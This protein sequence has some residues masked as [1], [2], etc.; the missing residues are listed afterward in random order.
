[1]PRPTPS[2][3]RGFTLIE[4]LVVIA[5]IA[6][7]AAILFPVFAQAREKARQTTCLSNLKQ[8]G[9]GMLM[10]AGDYDET[11]SWSTSNMSP[12]RS[13]YQNIE[14]YIKS[15]VDRNAN[16]SYKVTTFWSCPSFANKN[17]PR[18]PGDPDPPAW[19]VAAD[20]ARSYGANG[21][22]MP[23]WANATDGWFPGKRPATLASIDKPAQVVLSEHTWGGRVMTGGDDWTSGCMGDESGVSAGWMSSFYCAMRFV[24]SGGAVYLLADGHAKWF[25]GPGDSWRARSTMGVAWRKSL[26]PNAQAWFRED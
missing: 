13:W 16:G 8:V 23:S 17:I 2:P 5:I 15:G 18:L 7:L 10:Y 25:R 19:T 4:L 24:H 21:N 12:G 1:M 6:I 9:Q 3:K 26:A 20:V 11:L 14:P 22:L